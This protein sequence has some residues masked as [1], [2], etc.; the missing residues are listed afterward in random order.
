MDFCPTKQKR[1]WLKE[2]PKL[3]KKSPKKKCYDPS[4]FGK[5]EI[6]V[7]FGLHF[8]RKDDLANSF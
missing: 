2:L 1:M 4:L 3:T 8:E 6:L 5:T 7:I